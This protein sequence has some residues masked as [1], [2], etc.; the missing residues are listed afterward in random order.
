MSENI[1]KIV[2]KSNGKRQNVET[3]HE[4]SAKFDLKKL[5]LVKIRAI[6]MEF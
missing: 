4:I 1:K 5:I 6:L 2:E 3:F